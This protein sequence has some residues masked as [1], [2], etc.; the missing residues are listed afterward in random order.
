MVKYPMKEEP[1]QKRMAII[2]ATLPRL[3]WTG[4]KKINL[5][6]LIQLKN[7]YAAMWTDDVTYRITIQSSDTVCQTSV[8][9]FDKNHGIKNTNQ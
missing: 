4:S 9:G 6:D 7:K 2:Q 3:K 1:I 8:Y 5:I